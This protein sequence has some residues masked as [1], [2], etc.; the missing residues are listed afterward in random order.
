MTDY[1]VS[2]KTRVVSWLAIPLGVAQ[3]RWLNLTNVLYRGQKILGYINQ[4]TIIF[5]NW[6]RNV[7]V[8]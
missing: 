7:S 4:L 6:F 2:E 5:T 1:S 8:S 3:T